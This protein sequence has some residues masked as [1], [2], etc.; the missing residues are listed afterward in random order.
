MPSP[1]PECLQTPDGQ[2]RLIK[3]FNER[4]IDDHSAAWS[5]LWDT[6]ESDMWDRGKPSPAL[7]DLLEQKADA[8][9][10]ITPDG[11]RKSALVPGCGK[12]YDVV[13]LA[14]HG[15]DVVGLEVSATG[16]TVA[17]EY[18]SNELSKPQE[19]NF[20]ASWVD[21][22]R[23]SVSF[24]E[25]DFFKSDWEQEKKYDLIYDYTFLCALPPVL[26]SRWA[27]RMADLLTPGGMLICLEFPLYKDPKLPGPPWGL[28]GVHWNL[29]AEGGDG[30]IE[31]EVHQGP[32]GGSFTR[33]MYIKPERSYES[34]KGTDMVS[35][36]IRK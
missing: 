11:K 22:Q 36:Y 31:D 1:F 13:M 12:G 2:T 35:V 32:Q 34:G 19:Y 3:H 28:K 10:A 17:K 8:L 5:N 30:I 21:T 29:L 9:S 23:G 4:A 33:M 26:R 25:G 15:F 7:I 24:I 20:G 27:S 6:D 14:L 18:A 16:V